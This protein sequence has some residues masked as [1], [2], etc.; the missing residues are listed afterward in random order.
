MSTG[1]N[2]N[3][4]EASARAAERHDPATGGPYYSTGMSEG[5]GFLVRCK[6]AEVSNQVVDYYCSPE[7]KPW[8]QPQCEIVLINGRKRL[9]PFDI[10]SDYLGFYLSDRAL[11]VLSPLL[12][13][14]GELLPVTADDG[15]DW[16]LFLMVEFG[17]VAPLVEITDKGVIRRNHTD[18][19]KPLPRTPK[20]GLMPWRRVKGRGDFVRWY[21]FDAASIG[22]RHVFR[23]QHNGKLDWRI[24]V[25]HAFMQAATEYGLKGLDYHAT[26]R[27][28]GPFW[29]SDPHDKD[30]PFWY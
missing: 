9:E 24:F 21:D 22:G 10:S 16:H 18:M 15:T 5:S 12:H 27:P 1:G 25:S 29:H 14:G 7:P 6:A 23:A 11:R 13:T 26:R 4:A 19:P 2:R 17:P 8:A 20:A 28:E 30:F 3:P